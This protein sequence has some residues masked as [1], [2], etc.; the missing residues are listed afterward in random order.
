[1]ES[2]VSHILSEIRRLEEELED[3]IRTHEVKFLYRMDGT[4][5][6][7]EATVKKAHQK[8]KVGLYRWLRESSFRNLIS[9]PFIYS[10]ILP[11]M[12]L[13]LFISA[14]Q[15]ICFPLYRMPKVSR[16]KYIV[17]DRH[18]LSYLNVIE[19]FNCI[20]CG[21]ANGLL[22]YAREIGARTEEYWCPVKHAGKVLDPHRRYARFA[23]FGDPEA[24]RTQMADARR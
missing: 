4:K 2:R 20:Y 14:Y 15:A 21:Y 9:A 1:M 12:A 5:V 16:R 23:D 11:F 3:A 18:K 13:D 22:A 17:L 24:Y 6:R 8:L 7:F 19:K 10:M